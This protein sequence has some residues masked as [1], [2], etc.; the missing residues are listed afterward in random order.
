MYFGFEA[1]IYE[2][3]IATFTKSFTRILSDL[4]DIYD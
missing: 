3:D 4:C 2:C 1:S